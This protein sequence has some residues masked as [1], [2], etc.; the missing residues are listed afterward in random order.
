MRALAILGIG[1]ILIAPRPAVSEPYVS[2]QLGYASTEWSRGAPLN[3]VIDD[4]GFAYGVDLGFPFGERWGVELGAYG[5]EGFDA[6]GTPCPA[7]AFCPAVVTEF[8]GNDIEILKVALAPR[9]VIG[10]TRLFA[11]AGYYRA[12]IDTGLPLPDAKSR[13]RGFVF[14]V[15]ARW[16]F[17]DPWSV[18]VQATR[19]DDNLRQIMFGVG[20]GLRRERE[21]T[22]DD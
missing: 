11:T 5:Y 8:G 6:R 13:D 16:Y 2:A 4:R 12:T 3:G 19:F 10:E 21:Q 17:S 22:V 18:S 14:G 1:L 20:W 15:G 9:F 7:G